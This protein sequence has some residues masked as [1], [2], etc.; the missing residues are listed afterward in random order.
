MSEL[1]SVQKAEF[2]EFIAYLC[3]EAAKEIM[4]HYG[5]EVEIE[6]KSDATPVTLADRNAEKRIRE[7][8]AERYP[9]HGIIGEEYGRERE[10]ADFVWVLDPVDGTKSFISGVP[11]FATLIA[12]LYKGRP[13]IGAINQ[14]VLQQLV[15]GDCETTTLNG[16]PVS[17][18]PARKLSEATLCTTDPIRQ[19]LWQNNARWDDLPPKTALYRSWGDAGG[20][21]LLVSGFTDIMCDPLMEIWDC[22]AILPC[23]EG[24]G[25][26]ATGWKGGDAFDER[27]IIAAKAELHDEV[28]KVLYPES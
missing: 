10:D 1:S 7:I 9:E 24:A 14:P 19:T 17:G 25:I 11:L 6:R 22:A 5:P 12:L 13:V 8:L 3:E 28:M 26:K 15:I 18:R 27:C 20:Y 21:I 2:K 4:P 23:L 16:K